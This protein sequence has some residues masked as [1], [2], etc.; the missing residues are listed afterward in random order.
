MNKDD[1]IEIVNHGKFYQIS[2]FLEKY[3]KIIVTKAFPIS[4]TFTFF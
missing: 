3:M 2:L 1:R 4:S